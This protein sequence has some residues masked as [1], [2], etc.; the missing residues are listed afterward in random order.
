MK[1]FVANIQ[2]QAM[3]NK[4]F[5]QVIYTG[6][7]SQLVLMSLPPNGE[8]GLETHPGND[9]LFRFERGTG[10]VII[11]GNEHTVGVGSAVVVPAGAEHNVINT[12]SFEPLKMF[13]IYAPPHHR[14]G[15][16]HATRE[17]AESDNEAFDGVTTE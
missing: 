15:T 12:S 14:D 10:K 4:N 13:T 1:G 16:V 8:I 5:R 3:E 11:D 7:H 2:A 6:K 9:Q 17:Q